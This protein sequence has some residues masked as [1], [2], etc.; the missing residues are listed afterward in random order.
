MISFKIRT[1][2]TKTSRRK[3]IVSIVVVNEREEKSSTQ[4]RGTFF[5]MVN[6]SIVC[7]SQKDVT[8][9]LA[10]MGKKMKKVWYSCLG[11]REKVKCKLTYD[12]GSYT[13]CSI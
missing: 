4:K 11:K 10:K 2:A 13:L 6:F 1:G 3:L 9:C 12:Y 7:R 8:N 5:F